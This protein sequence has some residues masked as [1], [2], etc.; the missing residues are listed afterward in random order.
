MVIDLSVLLS[1]SSSS[2]LLVVLSTVLI[3]KCTACA[4]TSTGGN[5]GQSIAVKSMGPDT[6]I[7][8][9][10]RH[11]SSPVPEKHRNRQQNDKKAA[12]LGT[13]SFH[14]PSFL[15][16]PEKICESSACSPSPVGVEQLL[17]ELVTLSICGS[18]WHVASSRGFVHPPAK[19]NLIDSLQWCS[20]RGQSE[21]AWVGPHVRCW[22][23][24]KNRSLSLCWGWKHPRP[25]SAGAGEMCWPLEP[26]NNIYLHQFLTKSRS[27]PEDA[28]NPIY[29]FH[30]LRTQFMF[31]YN[32]ISFLP[33]ISATLQNYSKVQS[34]YFIHY[35]RK[36]RKYR[37]GI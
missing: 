33:L 22:S 28:L 29:Q 6:Q 10:R 14:I 24:K 23:L 11:Q 5:Q 17:D 31:A 2:Q 13:P 27:F 7:D 37:S 4:L 16:S 15:F 3:S 9:Q 12:D 35:Q 26:L 25:T 21:W 20:G 1:H 30:S 36:S 8:W 18:R 34:Q 19:S 32:S